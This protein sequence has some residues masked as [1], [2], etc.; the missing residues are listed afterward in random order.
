MSMSSSLQ[1][2]SSGFWHQTQRQKYL[3][4]SASARS[5]CFRDRNCSFQ[6]YR[7]EGYDLRGLLTWNP[8]LGVGIWMRSLRLLPPASDA[9]TSLDLRFFRIPGVETREALIVCADDG[10][11]GRFWIVSL[12]KVGDD[13]GLCHFG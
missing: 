8:N 3:T 6:P 1:F 7:S 13:Y 5:P 2:V 12:W 9:R 10:S 11:D 4:G